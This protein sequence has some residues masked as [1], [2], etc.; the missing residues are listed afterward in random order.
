MAPSCPVI[1]TVTV[2]R[3]APVQHLVDG[4]AVVV[5]GRPA[6]VGEGLDGA[7]RARCE[8]LLLLVLPFLALLG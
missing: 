7:V 3:L 6:H 5:G 8:L 4:D 1:I 2:M